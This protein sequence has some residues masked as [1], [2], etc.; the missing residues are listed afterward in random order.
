VVS[1]I[2]ILVTLLFGARVTP[3]CVLVPVVGL[4]TAYLFGAIGLIVTSYVKT[5]NNFA[6]FTSGVITP[7]FFFSGTF[8][9]ILGQHPLL[10]AVA[11]ALPLIHSIE[12]SRALYKAQFGWGTVFHVAVLAAYV[13]VCH[14]FALRRMTKRVL[15]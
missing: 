3:W 14:L 9:P 4:V 6:F 1:T 7:L 12:L 8:F 15:G 10:D 2:V 5:M 13:V 11:N